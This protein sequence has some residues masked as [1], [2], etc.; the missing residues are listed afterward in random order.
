MLQTHTL[1]VARTKTICCKD[2]FNVANTTRIGYKDNIY[3]LQRQHLYVAKTKCICCEDKSTVLGVSAP[4][5]AFFSP[6]KR[7]S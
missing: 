6:P 1:Y 4:A 7:H 3:R 2:I 5:G